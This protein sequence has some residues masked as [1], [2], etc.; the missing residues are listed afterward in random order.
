MDIDKLKGTWKRFTDD[1][2]E[3]DHQTEGKLNQLLEKK[4]QDSI[5]K[6]RKNFFL[7]AG[8]N[9][10]AIP[11][12]LLILLNQSFDAA[13]V[14]YVF[15]GF[16]FIVLIGF[17]I[18]LYL[19]YKNIYQIGHY[20]MTLEHKLRQQIESLTRFIHAYFR[21]TYVI[22]F[23]ALILGLGLFY[24]QEFSEFLMRFV[25]GMGIGIVLFFL[26]IR[27]FTRYYIRKQYRKHLDAL[28]SYLNELSESN[29]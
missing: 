9:V 5:R 22:Y 17:L 11:V 20:N 2:N 15:M 21:I 27:P 8:F 4:R 1:L 18:Y 23:F 14:K 7:D 10:A 25:V 6:L 3:K 26:L 16:V 24:Q 12:F 13:K 19:T 28:K 29:F